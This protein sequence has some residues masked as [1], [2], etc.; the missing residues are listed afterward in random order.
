MGICL[1]SDRI[2]RLD[3]AAQGLDSENGREGW[4]VL[5]RNGS[6]YLQK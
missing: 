3:R 6:V 1:G 4:E 2:L 5:L